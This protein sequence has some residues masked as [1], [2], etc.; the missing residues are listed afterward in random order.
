M[1]PWK[2]KAQ[3]KRRNELAAEIRRRLRPLLDEKAHSEK[4]MWWDQDRMELYGT[5]A[6]FL[7]NKK[8]I[9]FANTI[10]RHVKEVLKPE[11]GPNVFS[12][13]AIASILALHDS[14]LEPDTLK[15]SEEYLEAVVPFGMT[16]DFQFHGY[17]DNMPVMW[18]WALTL[19][20]DRFERKD[21]REVAWANLNQLK[22][23]L[24]RRGTVAEYGIGYATHRLTGIANIAECAKECEFRKMAE[25][26]EARLWAE[27]LGH[28]HP[29]LGV[30]CGASMRGGPP[31]P[32]EISALYC[33]VFG[34]DV[35]KPWMPV[36]E[37][38][39]SVEFV[40]ESGKDP[41]EYVFCYP[42]CY[43]PEFAGATYHVPDKLAKLVYEKPEN[44]SFQCTAENGYVNS[45]IF[46]KQ[47]PVYGVGG[48]LITAKLTDEVVVI[49]DAPELGAQPHG[50]TTF[51]GR[52]YGLGSST[53]NMFNTSHALRCSYSRTEKPVRKAD[54]GD[55]FIRYN[56]NGKIPDGRNKNTYWKGKEYPAEAE[57]YCNLYHDQGR[58]ACLQHDN[59]VMCLMTPQYQE[60]WDVRNMRAELFF[61]QGE[62][63]VKG[64]YVGGEKISHFPFSTEKEE[65]IDFD[66]GSVFM[67]IHPLIGRHLER[68]CAMKIWESEQYLVVSLYNYEGPSREFTQHEMPKLGNGFVM[69][70]RDAEEF[71][72][73]AS[74]QAQMAEARVLDQ[75]YGGRRRVHYARP[76]LRLS[77]HYCPYTHTRMQASVNG[78]EQTIPQLAFTG[79]KERGLPFLDGKES[80][81]FD[82]WDWIETQMKRKVE[83]YNPVE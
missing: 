49:K 61:Y 62:G 16:A 76:G 68:S 31:L 37:H 44:F 12:A 66:E 8:D 29:K 6:F 43:L 80:P 10:I 5:N 58:H 15:F 82:D 72:D 13:N 34:S 28:W 40:K 21:F 50:L 55:M 1:K 71:A 52:N 22:D 17:N 18:T 25:E 24:R 45:G 19:A 3:L 2:P 33:H 54:L 67:S 23:L 30:I 53:V 69:E 32:T 64:V 42:L 14:K 77:M 20:G 4:L 60:W 75:L 9:A 74:F 63:K 7:G 73:F 83:T 56:I 59:T 51:L 47:I 27:Q 70:T 79:G 35:E 46:C 41:K 48:I 57:N 26:I 36:L 38:L 78:R 81:G 11:P 65:R 39:D